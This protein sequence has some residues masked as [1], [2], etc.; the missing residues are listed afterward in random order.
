M[1]DRNTEILIA[2][3]G[4][5]VGA[6][7]LVM[8]R[9]RQPV[10]VPGPPGPPGTPAP[11]PS[12]VPAPAPVPAICRVP[13]TLIQDSAWYDWVTLQPL[14]TYEPAGTGVTYTEA[15]YCNGQWYDRIEGPG[16]AP[17][18][19]AIR[20]ANINT[21]G[22]TPASYPGCNVGGCPSGGAPPP[23]SP[24][25]CA[26]G[27]LGGYIYNE[28]APGNPSYFPSAPAKVWVRTQ[29]NGGTAYSTTA[30]G[31]VGGTPTYAFSCLPA[32]AT[33]HGWYLE[34]QNG[35]TAPL[36]F[37]G[38]QGAPVRKGSTTSAD[39]LTDIA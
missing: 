12:P 14:G 37:S 6:I 34:L 2:V 26:G 5:G 11:A 28:N 33:Y 19:W 27:A 23:P 8:S 38:G 39:L 10:V 36:L 31:K 9:N 21:G 13:G 4:L 35:Q 15:R 25:S 1:A 17:G 20:D 30:I 7:G 29:S 18:A 32:G 24:P 3:A 16:G 22:T